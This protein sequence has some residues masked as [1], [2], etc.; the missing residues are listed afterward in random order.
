[1][2]VEL[3]VN[4]RIYEVDVEPGASLREAIRDKLWLTGTKRGCDVGGCGSCTVLLDG[5]AVYSCM[6]FVARAEG[7]KIITIEGLANNGR[8]HPVQ[9]AFVE[10]GAVQCGYQE[11]TPFQKLPERRN[12]LVI[13]ICRVRW[14]GRY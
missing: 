13:Y 4:D 7:K 12:T 3:D 6:V 10:H 2:K 8:L 14:L 11:W 9:E 5:K 1:M